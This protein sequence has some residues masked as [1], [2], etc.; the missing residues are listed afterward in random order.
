M[1][2]RTCQPTL[3]DLAYGELA[4][5]LAT[6]VRAHVAGCASCGAAFKA[7]QQG[8]EGSEQLAWLEP[9]PALRVNALAY[10]EQYARERVQAALV[11]KASSRPRA[12]FVQSVFDFMG[13]LASGRQFA[14]ATVMVLVAVVGVWVIPE[15]QPLPAGQ[16]ITVVSPD[17]EGEAAPSG[18]LAPAEPLDLT[19]DQRSR[20]IRSRE[21]LD[22]A[23]LARSASEPS[24]TAASGEY[25]GDDKA[26]AA[27]AP[28]PPA[29]AN[30][31]DSPALEYELAAKQARPQAQ[32]VQDEYKRNAAAGPRDVA[33][34]KSKSAEAE[35]FPN[36]SEFAAMQPME[37]S[38][39]GR[40]RPAPAATSAPAKPRSPV[41]IDDLLDGALGSS[42]G[43]SAEARADSSGSSLER[44][45]TA[46]K[47]Q[48]CAAALPAY[49]QAVQEYS[50]SLPQSSVLG[51]ALLELAECQYQVGRESSARATLKRAEQVA[52]VAVRARALLDSEA[53]A[54][55][56]SKAK[57]RPAAAE[58]AAAPAP[59]GAASSKD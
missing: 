27:P 58:A 25:A 44:A 33:A 39:A 35:A 19:V 10:A 14:M 11:A 59:A 4:P 50:R 23:Q 9:P 12:P 46:R 37:E 43:S 22:E 32:P 16:G 57:A 53:P 5:E 54:E 1:D 31:L 41:A 8:I 18:G 21:E 47:S 2:C 56:R 55:P 38:S 15:L 34:P 24:A 20:R 45:R 28:A 17:P 48:G 40:A 30:E 36:N 7:L 3:L 52:P 49:E 42:K 29:A 26:E 51:S 6:V 13:R